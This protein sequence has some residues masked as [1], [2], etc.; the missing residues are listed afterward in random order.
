[1]P[2]IVMEFTYANGS[3]VAV[4]LLGTQSAADR[5]YGLE[6]VDRVENGRLA[7]KATSSFITDDFFSFGY[8][9]ILWNI[10]VLN[11]VI[12]GVFLPLAAPDAGVDLCLNI[13]ILIKKSSYPIFSTC[14]T[15]AP[16]ADKN[17]T[18]KMGFGMVPVM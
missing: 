10:K 13:P 17:M 8:L 9:C 6:K 15:I 16:N 2:L 11:P 4:E 3:A 5:I 7:T 1:M 14:M 18:L 12:S